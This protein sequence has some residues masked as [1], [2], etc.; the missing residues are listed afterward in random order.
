VLDSYRELIDELLATPTTV[1]QL[2]SAQPPPLP[3]AVTRLIAELRDRDLAV[4]SRLQA[5]MHERNPYL[6]AW[7]PAEPV[8]PAD[9]T[10]L[11]E[12]L[13]TARGDLVSLLMNLTLKQWENVAS[14]EV[15]GEI[16][17]AEEVERHVEFDEQQV[18]AIQEAL[19]P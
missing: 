17:L 3:A 16:T 4:T 1:G 14:H 6:A 12:E 19:R 7:R 10:A 18:A 2:A 5:I 8:I 11:L 15:D 13:A 9:A